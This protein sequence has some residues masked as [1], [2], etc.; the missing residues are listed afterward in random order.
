MDNL[1]YPRL[2][3]RVTHNKFDNPKQSPL[4]HEV[5]ELLQQ[6]YI[7]NVKNYLKTMN[8]DIISYTVG[9]HKDAEAPHIHLHFV[10]DVG[11]SK[12]PKVFIQDWKYKFQAGKVPLILP[13]NPYQGIKVDY[14]CLFSFKHKKKINISIKWTDP[15]PQTPL[16]LS[17]EEKLENYNRYL[18]YPLKEGF[19]VDHNLDE[20]DLERLR[21]QA[22]GEWNAVKIKKL[23]EQQQQAKSETEYGKICDIISTH[24]PE[25]YTDAVRLVLDEVKKNRVEY[26]EHI[27]PRNLISSVQKYCYHVG[28]WTIDEIIE[29]Y[30]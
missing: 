26:R 10:V 9:L 8:Y 29:K 21:S 23:R 7:I 25:C 19:V 2:S 3:F 4:R 24:K 16:G 1:D 12:I 13:T 28:I 11:K 18:A 15:K 5:K 22:M 27:N 20:A 30:A 17:I 14:P 6:Y